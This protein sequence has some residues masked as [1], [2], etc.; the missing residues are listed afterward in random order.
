MHGNRIT[1]VGALKPVFQRHPRDDARHVAGHTGCMSSAD[2]VL[3]QGDV[4]GPE[5]IYRAISQ[6]NLALASM[7]LE[8]AGGWRGDW[9][10]ATDARS[11]SDD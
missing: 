8:T 4:P 9:Y 11:R 3:R 10:A 2:E 6:A 7:G 5:P 1:S